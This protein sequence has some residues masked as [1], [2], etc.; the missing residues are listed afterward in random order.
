VLAKAKRHRKAKGW[1]KGKIPIVNKFLAGLQEEGV[2]L[3]I[4]MK[5]EGLF[6]ICQ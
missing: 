3:V 4:P 5:G 2:G 6:L 1:G